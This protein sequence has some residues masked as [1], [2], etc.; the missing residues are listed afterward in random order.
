MIRSGLS[1]DLSRTPSRW[2]LVRD[3]L[4]F[5]GKLFLDGVRD[6]VLGPLSLI[7]AVLD[8]LGVGRTAGRHFYD[9]VLLGRKTED[10][11]N[12]FGSADALLPTE[13]RDDSPRGLDVLVARLE[14]LVMQEYERGG[15]TASAKRVVDRAL[16]NVQTRG[17]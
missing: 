8:L 6:L 14:R 3:A 13:L 15:I 17:E 10:W 9:V 5:Q 4:V 16:D 1:G 12:L 11:I 2:E 7:A